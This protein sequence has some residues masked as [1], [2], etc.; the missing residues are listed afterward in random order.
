MLSISTSI[1]VKIANG[2]S[3]HPD[4]REVSSRNVSRAPMGHYQA[5][6]EDGYLLG[7]W[8]TCSTLITGSDQKLTRVETN[9][10]A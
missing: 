6:G 7:I 1:M 2:T 8:F 4:D 10:L 3:Q 9:R 5:E